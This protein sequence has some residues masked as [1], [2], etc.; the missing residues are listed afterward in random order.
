[1]LR[2]KLDGKWEPEDFIDVFRGVE[3]LYYKAA[4]ERS[5]RHQGSLGWPGSL[6]STTFERHVEEANSWFLSEARAIALP[7]ERLRITC[8]EYGSP[9]IIDIQGVGKVLEVLAGAIGRSVTFFAERDLR[10]ERMKQ[11]K[12]ESR[13]MEIGLEFEE[14]SVRALKLANAQK[15]LEIRQDYPDWPEDRFLLLAV[16]DLDKLL[17]RIAEGKLVG[18]MSIRGESPK[19]D[20]E[21]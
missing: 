10:K 20:K 21:A 12:L 16:S 9:G 1:M 18:A 13:K 11:A 8:I 2:L 14:E 17:P 15:L 19:G 3:S 5:Y 7:Q 6:W 4:I